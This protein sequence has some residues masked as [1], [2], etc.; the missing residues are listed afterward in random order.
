[1][2]LILLEHA[3][4]CENCS[5]IFSRADSRTGDCPACKSE[6]TCW[7]RDLFARVRTEAIQDS[8]QPFRPLFMRP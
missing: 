4:F 6:A 5:I 8:V 3:R 1:M 2:N 7:L